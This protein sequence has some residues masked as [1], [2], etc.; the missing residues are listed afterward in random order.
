[1]SHCCHLQNTKQQ[2]STV[3]R[4]ITFIPLRRHNLLLSILVDWGPAQSKEQGHLVLSP[5][6]HHHSFPI[7]HW[8]IAY[9]ATKRNGK[10]KL[11][12][13]I[14]RHFLK[15]STMQNI[16]TRHQYEVLSTKLIFVHIV[17]SILFNYKMCYLV[18]TD[19]EEAIYECISTCQRGM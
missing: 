1:M 13:K 17:L 7:Y 6:S 2:N 3:V 19:S 5:Q 11:Y 8:Q 9:C 14:D 4:M 10:K 12:S 18:Q 16:L 15:F